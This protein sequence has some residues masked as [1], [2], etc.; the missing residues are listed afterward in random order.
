MGYQILAQFDMNIPY[1]AKRWW[2][3]TLAN[4]ASRSEFTKALPAKVLPSIANNVCLLPNRQC[5]FCQGSLQWNSPMFCA[6]NVSR[7]TVLDIGRSQISYIST[8]LIVT[9]ECV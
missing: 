7:Y 8:P 5:F 3:K 4:L 9:Y 2:W 1:S 6:A